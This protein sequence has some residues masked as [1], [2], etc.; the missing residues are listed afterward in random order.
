MIILVVGAVM[1]IT[2]FN[3]INAKIIMIL[4]IVHAFNKLFVQIF[5]ALTVQIILINVKYVIYNGEVMD[6]II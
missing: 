6:Y 4:L 2:Q 5:T 1:V 3:V